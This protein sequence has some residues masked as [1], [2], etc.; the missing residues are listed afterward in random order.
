MK[1]YAW[2][3]HITYPNKQNFIY[4]SLEDF[5]NSMRTLGVSEMPRLIERPKKWVELES[6]VGIRMEI[7]Y[8]PKEIEKAKSEADEEDGQRNR[9]RGTVFNA[10]GI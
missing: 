6:S 8:G 2:H 7:C 4:V 3:V 10:W 1:D 5:E 9:S